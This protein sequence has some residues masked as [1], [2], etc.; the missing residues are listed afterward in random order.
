MLRVILCTSCQLLPIAVLVLYPSTRDAVVVHLAR[1]GPTAQFLHDGG[2]Y[3]KRSKRV[4]TGRGCERFGEEFLLYLRQVWVVHIPPCIETIELWSVEAALNFCSGHSLRRFA[5]VIFIA[6]FP[7][8]Y[9]SCR[10][11]VSAVA[12]GVEGFSYYG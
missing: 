12:G 3:W 6:P 4:F 7:L 5:I 1:E 11:Y 8:G 10:S 2:T 9:P